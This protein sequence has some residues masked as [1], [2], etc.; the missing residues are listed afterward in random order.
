MGF[1]RKIG[2]VVLGAVLLSGCSSASTEGAASPAQ[3]P[4][5][6]SPATPSPTAP[7]PTP[8]SPPTPTAE[9][10]AEPAR[11]VISTMQLQVLSDSGDVLDEIGIFDAIDP[12]VAI[13]TD[14][15]DAAPVVTAYEGT[16]AADYEWDGF[17][18]GTDGPANPP[19]GA[20]VYVRAETSELNGIGIETVGGFAV[21]D[22]LIPL[23]EAAPEDS[24]TW[25]N[26]G[27][28]EMV[29]NVDE[30]PVELD[31]VDR[32]LHTELTANPA[33][34]PISQISAPAKNFE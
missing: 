17:M 28:L 16:S 8:S 15:F 14:L 4:S 34:G 7:S 21:G 27:V 20:E 12:A 29:V 18:I 26:Q 30:V 9:P 11:L 6:A 10:A 31:E 33:D 3:S 19:T 13:L 23:S 2:I 22:S 25:D 1:G 5:A 32:A 24:R